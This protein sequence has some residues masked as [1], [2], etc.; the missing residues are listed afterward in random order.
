MVV[1]YSFCTFC[2]DA[3]EG[4][5]KWGQALETDCKMGD[6]LVKDGRMEEIFYI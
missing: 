5:G 3:Y 1:H 2:T 4:I 6:A